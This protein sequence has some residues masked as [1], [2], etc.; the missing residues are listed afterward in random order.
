MGF[1]ILN[2]FKKLRTEHQ[3]LIAVGIFIIIIGIFWPRPSNFSVGFSAHLGN[4]KGTVELEAFEDGPLPVTD[5][6][7]IALFYAPWCGYCKKFMPIWDKFW[8]ANKDRSDV[9][10]TKINADKFTDMSKKAGVSGY[11]TLVYFSRG[12]A[13]IDVNQVFDRA[14][15]NGSADYDALQK[16]L[17]NV[18]PVPDKTSIQGGN[19]D[20][21]GPPVDFA[22][23]G[24]VSPGRYM[25]PTF[26]DNR[27]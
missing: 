10:I 22:G 21:S 4:L 8:Q 14:G 27:N 24:L 2:R 25:Q 19:V 16:F 15:D 20:G 6:K 3:I 9:I 23:A 26:N 11:P 7:T 1:D 18:A 13:N 17:N 12:L 5:K